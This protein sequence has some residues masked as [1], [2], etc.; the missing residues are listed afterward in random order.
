MGEGADGVPGM[1]LVEPKRTLRLP[2]AGTSRHQGAREYPLTQ[3]SA[4]SATPGATSMPT[5]AK[6]GGRR[7]QEADEADHADLGGV[8]E[9]PVL[10]EGP[11]RVGSESLG[12][13]S[14]RR[15]LARG[16]ARRG[17]A[18]LAG[19]ERGGERGRRC[20]MRDWRETSRLH[21][22]QRREGATCGGCQATMSWGQGAVELP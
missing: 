18:K 22:R 3:R 13:E 15:P 9:R 14:R 11:P 16:R 8:H 1:L 5:G 2:E 6:G 10:R 17:G 21:G 19:K 7:L 20:S 4:A 12:E